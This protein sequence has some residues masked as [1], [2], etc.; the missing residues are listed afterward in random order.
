MTKP[1]FHGIFIYY[2]SDVCGDTTCISFLLHTFSI[3][4][5]PSSFSHCSASDPGKMRFGECHLL[6]PHSLYITSEF[7]ITVADHIF[8]SFFFDPSEKSHLATLLLKKQVTGKKNKNIL[9]T[10]K[11]FKSRSTFLFHVNF[12]PIQFLRRIFQSYFNV[13][14]L[15]FMICS[16]WFRTMN[17]KECIVYFFGCAPHTYF[18]ENN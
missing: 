2:W 7:S 6:K 10:M 9:R 12:Y 16:I 18:K 11:L 17:S 1:A 14:Y 5:F 4:S 15:D 8:Q 13:L 3:V